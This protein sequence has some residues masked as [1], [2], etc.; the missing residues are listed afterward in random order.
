MGLTF[1]ATRLPDDTV[2]LEYAVFFPAMDRIM[3]QR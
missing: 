2:A 3:V 1:G